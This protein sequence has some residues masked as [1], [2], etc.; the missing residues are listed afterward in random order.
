[1]TAFFG[2]DTT[3]DMCLKHGVLVGRFAWHNLEHIPMFDD[4]ATLIE[5]EDVDS[6]II[7]VSRPVLEAVQHHEIALRNG[8]LELDAFAGIFAR[9]ALDAADKGPLPV[10]NMRV[11]LDVGNAYA[12]LNGS[13]GFVLIEYQIVKRR[14]VL[15]VLR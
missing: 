12:L 11:V 8:A 13:G 6:G 14:H 9:P 4:F 10:A 2:P 7:M 5:P 15:F 1:M 3:S